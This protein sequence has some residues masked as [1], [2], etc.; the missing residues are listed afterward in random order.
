MKSVSASLP[1]PRALAQHSRTGPR[2]RPAGRLLVLLAASVA[3]CAHTGVNERAAAA[4]AAAK[5]TQAPQPGISAP[6]PAHPLN[7]AAVA[8]GRAPGPL[9]LGLF[10]VQLPSCAADASPAEQSFCAAATRAVRAAYEDDDEDPSR[11]LALNNALEVQQELAPLAD[12]WR[13]PLGHALARSES[14]QR[15]GPTLRL[16]RRAVA[17]AYLDQVSRIYRGVNT[18]ACRAAF[19]QLPADEPHW[20]EMVVTVEPLGTYPLSR[21]RRFCLDSRTLARAERRLPGR[22]A[23]PELRAAVLQLWRDPEFVAS[24]KATEVRVLAPWHVDTSTQVATRELVVGAERTTAAA[25]AAGNDAAERCHLERLVLI[26][27]GPTGRPK[28]RRTTDDGPI[29]CTALHP[30]RPTPKAGA[31]WGARSAHRRTRQHG[32]L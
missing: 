10:E 27:R 11:L 15:I 5:T 17:D 19:A 6:A 14:L 29:A 4:A 9:S 3:A 23:D 32:S 31:R 28:V 12:A 13:A 30:G 26:R 16:L 20:L 22:P 2:A 1:S 7:D 25:L 8:D 21:L 18:E 24:G